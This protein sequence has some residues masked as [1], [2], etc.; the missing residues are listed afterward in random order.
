[1]H[2][3]RI[4]PALLLLVA[5]AACEFSRQPERAAGPSGPA[6]WDSCTSFAFSG[7]YPIASGGDYGGNSSFLYLPGQRPVPL[8][9][10][11][12]VTRELEIQDALTDYC[13]RVMVPRGM[14]TYP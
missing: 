6:Q 14:V 13:R 1:M 5:L 10:G 8:E 4:L 7:G 2:R 9:T 12:Y 11:N 3:I